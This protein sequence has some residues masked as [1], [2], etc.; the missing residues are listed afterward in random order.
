MTNYYLVHCFSYPSDCKA[1]TLLLSNIIILVE[2]LCG[3]SF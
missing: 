2:K 1:L 3:W